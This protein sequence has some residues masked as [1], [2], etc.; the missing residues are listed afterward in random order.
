MSFITNSDIKSNLIHGFDISDYIAESDEEIYDVAEKLGIRDRTLIVTPIHY[1]IKRYAIVFV[2][3]R[4]AQDKI[5]TNQPD[6]QVEKY[7]ELYAMY[8]D[9]L[10]Y[11]YTQL[12]Y[13]MFTGTVSSITGRTSSSGLYRG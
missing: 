5:G 3:M 10:K 9:E 6:S 12:T 11:V 7:R 13:E 2:L 4:L 1:K 8:S